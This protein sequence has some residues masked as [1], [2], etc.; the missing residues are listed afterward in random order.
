MVTFVCLSFICA[1]RPE[2]KSIYKLSDPFCTAW[3]VFDK[4][5]AWILSDVPQRHEE[6]LLARICWRLREPLAIRGIDSL[7]IAPD[8]ITDGFFNRKGQFAAAGSTDIVFIDRE[9]EV[10]RLKKRPRYAVVGGHYR[11]NISKVVNIVSPDTIVLS[12]S[13]D[14]AIEQ[15]FAAQLDSLGYPYTRSEYRYWK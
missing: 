1:P 5:N 4:G 7:R 15:K 6:A 9:N 12:P 8:T 2:A 13:L 11:H 14:F 10:V 3:V